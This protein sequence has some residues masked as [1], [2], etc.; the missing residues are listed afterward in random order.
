MSNTHPVFAALYDPLT[1]LAERRLQPHREWL[2]A[3]LSGSVLDLG[4]GTGAMFPSLCERDL[5]LHAVDPDPH[6]RKR[7]KRR[8]SELDCEIAINE[9]TA[10]SLPYPDDYFDGVVSSLVLCSVSDVDASVAE[11]TRVLS[12]GGECRFL[13]HV[14]AD[15]WQAKIQEG[16]TPC[17]QHVAGGCQLDRETPAAFVSNPDIRIETLQRVLVGLPPV[18]PIIRGH[19]IHD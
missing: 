8:A 3:D 13:E 9:G 19:A 17:W 18:S 15:G 6:M 7:A 4:C 12:P 14:R 2:V 10:E 16:L 11:I 5:D 1:R